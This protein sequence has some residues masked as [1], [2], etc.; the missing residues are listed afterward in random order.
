MC[1]IPFVFLASGIVIPVTLSRLQ[2]G[3][4]LQ[5]F[6]VPRPLDRD[7]GGCGLDLPQI[8]GGQFDAHG[9]DVLVQAL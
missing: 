9:A 1:R 5:G 4:L 8:L 7:L 3:P 6:G 2:A